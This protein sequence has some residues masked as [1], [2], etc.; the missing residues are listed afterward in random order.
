MERVSGIRG[1]LGSFRRRK[2]FS[3]E[4]ARMNV[5]ESSHV[6]LR[7]RVGRAGVQ[8]GR[9]CTRRTVPAP[10]R[11]EKAPLDREAAICLG[12]RVDMRKHFGGE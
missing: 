10:L 2:R 12:D 7:E 9:Q 3:R 11:G 4:S 6:W 1:L 8:S 5:G